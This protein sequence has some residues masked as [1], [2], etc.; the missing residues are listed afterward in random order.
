MTQPFVLPR[1]NIHG[2]RL[3]VISNPSL[4]LGSE[5]SDLYVV[6]D[7]LDECFRAGGAI[8]GHYTRLV[9]ILPETELAAVHNNIERALMLYANAPITER[10]GVSFT[11]ADSMV[12]IYPGTGVTCRFG[13]GGFDNFQVILFTAEN[14]VTDFDWQKMYEQEMSLRD[15][16]DPELPIDLAAAFEAWRTRSPLSYPV[17]QIVHLKPREG[18]DPFTFDLYRQ[19]RV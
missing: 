15:Y 10:K 4:F 11:R 1:T 9:I 6:R 3:T 13:N 12:S 2:I 18:N 8:N 7:L 17:A 14:L 5:L 19:Q 16:R